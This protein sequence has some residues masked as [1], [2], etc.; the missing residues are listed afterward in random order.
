MKFS[1]LSQSRLG[2]CADD[3]R[4]I[5]SNAIETSQVDFGIAEGFRSIARQQELFRAVPKVTNIDGIN[6]L[7]KHNYNPSR[8]V[9]IYGWVNDKECYSE[10]TLCY[11]AGHIMGVAALLLKE[12][13]ILHQ[14]RWG[15]N[16]DED[17]EIITDQR[18]QDLVHFEI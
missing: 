14:L 12:G 17:G 5:F 16:W 4:I 10:R 11:L 9:D 7:G 6:V 13:K 18:L 8:A 15:G 1:S 3:L 2:T